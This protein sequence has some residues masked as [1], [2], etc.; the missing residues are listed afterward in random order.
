M[1]QYILPGGLLLVAVAVLPIAALAGWNETWPGLPLSVANWVYA[2][3]AVVWS[4]DAVRAKPPLWPHLIAV[5]APPAAPVAVMWRALQDSD[6]A[7]LGFFAF[8]PAI[9]I[10][11]LAS[12]VASFL[13]LLRMTWPPP[14]V[15]DLSDQ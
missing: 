13:L 9:F 11:L 5:W 8:A 3:G 10:P 12:M 2:L 7:A 1:R 15:G 4:I 14:G 6:A